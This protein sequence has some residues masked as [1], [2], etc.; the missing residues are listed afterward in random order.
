MTVD[1]A[2]H[3]MVY[4]QIRT[5]EVTSP[6]ILDVLA[7]TPREHFVP[8]QMK[9]L[10]FAE[11]SI[12]LDEG[13]QMLPPSLIGKI[14]QALPI[15]TEQT[16]LEIGTGSG[17]LTALLAQLASKVTSLELYQ[18]ITSQAKS[19]LSNLPIANIELQTTNGLEGYT[20]NAPYDGIVITAALDQVPDT[21][22]QQVKPGGYIFAMINHDGMSTAVLMTQDNA[23]QWET[24]TLFETHVPSLQALATAPYFEF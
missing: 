4:R 8:T 16:L 20:Q 12:P 7:Q 5:W 19:N 2:H 18:T 21:L 15:S 3:N 1:L 6:K 13:S 9:E 17:Y 10:A 23:R 24:T 11:V 14:L 22:K